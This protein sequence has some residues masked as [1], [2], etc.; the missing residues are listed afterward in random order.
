MQEPKPRI[1]LTFLVGFLTTGFVGA[2]IYALL[3]GAN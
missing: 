1:A 3:A 2:F